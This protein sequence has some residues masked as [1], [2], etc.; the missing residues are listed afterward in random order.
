MKET[1]SEEELE[2]VKRVV[3]LQH[4]IKEE[5]T[6]VSRKKWVQESSFFETVTGEKICNM[7]SF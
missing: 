4:R 2:F 6:E 1:D 5:M 3:Q 7:K